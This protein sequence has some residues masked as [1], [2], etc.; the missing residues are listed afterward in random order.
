MS[1]QILIIVVLLIILGC[2]QDR[3]ENIDVHNG[4]KGNWSIISKSKIT[5]DTIF[6][7]PISTCDSINNK[8][9]ISTEDSSYWEFCSPTSEVSKQNIQ[10]YAHGDPEY[11]D[12]SMKHFP[13][14]EI[15]HH[16]YNVS[17]TVSG[18]IIIL[19]RLKLNS[20]TIY[21]DIFEKD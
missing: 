11:C 2:K 16:V 4:L 7:L 9:T 14:N 10:F 20:D 8:I 17:G 12:V 21:S 19:Y 1:R 15:G 3:C 6:Y 13:N 5:L 18:E